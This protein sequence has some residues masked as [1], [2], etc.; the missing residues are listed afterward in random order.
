MAP[1]RKLKTRAAPA[2]SGPR[3]VFKIFKCFVGIALRL[4]GKLKRARSSKNFARRL[5]EFG[6]SKTPKWAHQEKFC[7]GARYLSPSA[8]ISQPPRRR[9]QDAR[10]ARIH[11]LA[12]RL[13]VRARAP[14][15]HNKRAAFISAS[16]ARAQVGRA[17]RVL[18]ARRAPSAKWHARVFLGARAH[19]GADEQL[20]EPLGQTQ[21]SSF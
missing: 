16:A 13:G 20:L 15:P 4:S 14:N 19:E 3:R 12:R 9:Q 11:C 18:G 7:A 2:V 10:L 5:I 17:P 21:V 1:A 6:L 8:R